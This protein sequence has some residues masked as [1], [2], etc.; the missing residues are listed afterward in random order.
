MT[1]K[2]LAQRALWCAQERDQ[3][4]RLVRATDLVREHAREIA[5][6]AEGAVFRVPSHTRPGAYYVVSLGRWVRECADFE[7]RSEPC[8][9]L[10]AA[11]IVR[12]KSSS[13]ADCGHRFLKRDLVEVTGDHES[14]TWFVGDELCG[15]CARA[16]GIL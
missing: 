15:G 6:S 1:E 13:C 10:Y 9:H 4:S 3:A 12:T 11:E 16:H 8:K 5:E 7:H 2:S 14:L